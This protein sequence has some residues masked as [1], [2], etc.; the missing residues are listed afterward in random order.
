MKG[1]DHIL[2]RKVLNTGDFSAINKGKKIPFTSLL[3]KLIRV[4]PKYGLLL[5]FNH[6]AKGTR[7]IDKLMSQYPLK[8][9]EYEHWHSIFFP[10]FLKYMKSF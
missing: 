8:P 7:I 2:K 9:E 1:F 6:L 10:W 5:K 4:T 3:A